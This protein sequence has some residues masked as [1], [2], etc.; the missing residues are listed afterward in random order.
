IL[1]LNLFYFPIY[2]TYFFIIFNIYSLYLSDY[3]TFFIFKNFDLPFLVFVYFLFF[4]KI[5]FHL[6][7]FSILVI[8]L[9]NFF[10]FRSTFICNF[11][12]I[13]PSSFLS[14]FPCFSLFFSFAY[15]LLYYISVCYF[16][17]HLFSFHKY[18]YTFLFFIIFS[19]VCL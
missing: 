10:Y 12:V 15:Y 6:F 19:F 18:L 16:Y 14:Y 9:L 13:L 3:F 1:F 17:I 7:Y 8:Q 2:K 5:K 4:A 11:L